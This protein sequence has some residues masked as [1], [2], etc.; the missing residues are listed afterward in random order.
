MDKASRDGPAT[1][2]TFVF[3]SDLRGALVFGSL[4]VGFV[5]IVRRLFKRESPSVRYPVAFFDVFVLVRA[6]VSRVAEVVE[7]FACGPCE[8]G[9]RGSWGRDSRLLA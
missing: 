7:R 8:R 4:L 2:L 9:V 5:Y 3:P 6:G 1:A